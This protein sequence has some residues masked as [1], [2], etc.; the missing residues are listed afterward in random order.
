MMTCLEPARAALEVSVNGVEWGSLSPIVH[1]KYLQTLLHR[2][3]D[4]FRRTCVFDDSREG[5]NKNTK[6]VTK[7][8]H[9][10]N[11]RSRPC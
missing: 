4:A 8:E 3:Y 7:R 11:T 1:A 9:V 6:Q 2:A 10:V 5:K